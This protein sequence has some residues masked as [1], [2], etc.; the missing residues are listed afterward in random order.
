MIRTAQALAWALLLL[1]VL[2]FLCRYLASTSH[3]VILAATGAPYAVLVA[4]TGL[5]IL[6]GARRWLEAIAALAV[7]AG[8]AAPMAAVLLTRAK[9]PPASLRLSVLTFNMREGRANAHALVAAVRGRGVELLMLQE[10]TPQ[11]LD[12]LNA[13]GLQTV[14]PYSYTE[15]KPRASGVGIFSA[16][17]L[18]GYRSYSGFGNGVISAV[19]TRP[20]G[21]AVTVFSSHLG[22]PWPQDALGWRWQSARLGEILAGT[23]GPLIDAGDFNASTSLKPFR[24]LLHAGGVSD[25]SIAAGDAG[26]RTYPSNAG[27]V[28]PLIGI[29]HVLTRQV[30]AGSTETVALPGS[31]HRA[32]AA[33]LYVPKA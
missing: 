18:T 4:L 5:A 7:M 14:L 1:A 19:L 3:I 31:D 2:V 28:P 24:N 27:L 13:A 8:L 23:P 17:P 20:T 11:A 21:R 6:V 29:D 33:T 32:L 25:A 26:I 15:P 30:A 22:A 16:T 10:M 12:Q 9:I